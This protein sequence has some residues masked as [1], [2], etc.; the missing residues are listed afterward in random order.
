MSA[1]DPKC[2]AIG[3]PPHLHRLGRNPVS[4]FSG[5]ER[6]F[7]RF[8]PGVQLVNNKPPPTVFTPDEQSMVRGKF[9]K[10]CEDVL[11]NVN[12][13]EHF[14][15]WGIVELHV[16]Q[17]ETM[18]TTISAPQRREFTFKVFHEPEDCCYAHSEIHI[19]ENG[20]RVREVKPKSVRFY[21]RDEL[22]DR[23]QV[24][25]HPNT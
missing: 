5:D 14:F 3:I 1:S 23:C 6:L 17:I 22:A 15:G 7:V 11:Y 9:A 25:K 10:T 13:H 24:I 21:I 20:E 4:E 19:F 8:M 2:A 12:G 18:A 16:S